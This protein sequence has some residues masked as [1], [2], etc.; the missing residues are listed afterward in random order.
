MIFDIILFI[1]RVLPHTMLKVNMILNEYTVIVGCV[2]DYNISWAHSFFAS[3]NSQLFLGPP[4]S[5]EPDRF[6]CCPRDQSL[7][8][9]YYIIIC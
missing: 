2:V 4:E 3:G 7:F 6:S 8:V 5:L 9:Y 1:G